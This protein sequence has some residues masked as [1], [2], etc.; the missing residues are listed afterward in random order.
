[1]SN[2]NKSDILFEDENV[3]ILDPTSKRGILII[4]QSNANVCE[5]GLYSKNKLFE[6]KHELATKLH[7]PKNMFPG[8]FDT[9]YFRAPYTSDTTNF[10]TL[11]PNYSF[12]ENNYYVLIRIDPYKTYVYN[13]EG[14]DYSTYDK[15]IKSK[16]NMIDYFD[17]IT[18]NKGII[19]KY[20]KALFG[21][22][23]SFAKKINNN[24][25]GNEIGTFKKYLPTERMGEILVIIEHIPKEW[26]YYC[27]KGKINQSQ[28]DNRVFRFPPNLQ[29]LNGGKQKLKTNKKKK[30]KKHTRK[31]MMIANAL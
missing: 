27:G 5:E 4:H 2:N 1:M 11:Y 21:N 14:R 25:R 7:S 3:C 20:P 12:N 16:T 17:I 15:Y 18:K 29:I 22:T 31:I 9:I 19:A 30:L 10:N 24:K 8:H 6:I 28:L 26:F 23:I 13:Q